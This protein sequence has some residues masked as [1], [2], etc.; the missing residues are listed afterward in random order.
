MKRVPSV[1]FKMRTRTGKNVQNPFD[2]MDKTSEDLFKGKRCV[3]F[4]LPGF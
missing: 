2:W 3:L 4:A 1:I